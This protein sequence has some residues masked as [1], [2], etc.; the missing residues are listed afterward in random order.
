M[1]APDE[2]AWPIEEETLDVP[3][4]GWVIAQLAT[5]GIRE[6]IWCV[7]AMGMLFGPAAAFAAPPM[8]GAEDMWLHDIVAT[9]ARDGAH[10]TRARS[11]A[12]LGSVVLPAWLRANTQYELGGAMVDVVRY[13]LPPVDR[14]AAGAQ[15]RLQIELRRLADMGLTLDMITRNVLALPSAQAAGAY[16]ASPVWLGICVALRADGADGPT[17]FPVA[18]DAVRLTFSADDFE[19]VGAN[20]AR[21]N[22]VAYKL[23]A[24]RA[25]TEPLKKVRAIYCA[26][27]PAMRYE[28]LGTGVDYKAGVPPADDGRAVA[29]M[30]ITQALW[31]VRDRWLRD[32]YELHVRQ[33]VLL[34]LCVAH[35][36]YLARYFMPAG[37]DPRF[38][39][40][41]YLLRRAA[42]REFA[43]TMDTHILDQIVRDLRHPAVPYTHAVNEEEVRYW[44][45]YALEREYAL[46]MLYRARATARAATTDAARRDARAAKFWHRS[47]ARALEA[48]ALPGADIAAGLELGRV[49]VSEAW[50]E[51]V[52]AQWE[53]AHAADATADAAVGAFWDGLKTE[54]RARGAMGPETTAPPIRAALD[55]IT[56][57]AYAR[58]VLYTF[59]EETPVHAAERADIVSAADRLSSD[60][61][62]AFVR[63][64]PA[65]DAIIED[66]FNYF[67]H[68]W[69]PLVGRRSMP[70][71]LFE[72][73]TKHYAL[74]INDT[75]VNL[76]G[77]HD[78]SIRAY[79]ATQG[80]AYATPRVVDDEDVAILSYRETVARIAVNAYRA[81]VAALN[82]HTDFFAHWTSPNTA[83]ARAA[84]SYV[85]R[86]DAFEHTALR[87]DVAARA[88]PLLPPWV[89]TCE[90][91][92]Q[93]RLVVCAE[94][95]PL[96]RAW[97]NVRVQWTAVLSY[98]G[99]R[100]AGRTEITH[101]VMARAM[102]QLELRGA[103]LLSELRGHGARRCG[104]THRA[105]VTV[106]CAV[107]GTFFT[108]A[109]VAARERFQATR[110]CILNIL[111]Y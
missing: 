96:Y 18:L 30:A 4:A 11:G 28:M 103:T 101:A 60:A 16:L 26:M 21:T 82:W 48:Y 9:H 13:A 47:Y 49:Q 56:R 93:A 53:Y 108:A 100:E 98:D 5:A 52:R 19:E 65:K 90:E 88:R 31:A 111:D 23:P 79:M 50:L 34:T 70:R 39:R 24:V 43:N 105:M 81:R 78:Q 15:A 92:G 80:N 40:A 77:L 87:M 86:L 95:W 25:S 3:P 99:E 74:L 14:T 75:N 1:A 110:T 45:W 8:A 85:A 29:P 41:A 94:A 91:L 54:I 71:M 84:L 106:Y 12:A 63:E 59:H 73:H 89:L 22:G 2:I 46:A 33:Y 62:A 38:A 76:Q 58:F 51:R 35:V 107:E 57:A 104:A 97:D 36:E 83:A 27:D 66:L 61:Y 72:L 42:V 109:R 44:V 6:P 37:G 69:V 20:N 32:V 17:H 68:V 64:M 67:C 55:G 10:P 102:P 7:R